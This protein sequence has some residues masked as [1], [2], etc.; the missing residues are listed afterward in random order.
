[1]YYLLHHNRFMSHLS[2]SFM[3]RRMAVMKPE[4]I[5]LYLTSYWLS[6][7]PLLSINSIL[8]ETPIYPITNCMCNIGYSA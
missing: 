2:S 4:L 8:F 6:E 1:M 7:C 5:T 3:Q